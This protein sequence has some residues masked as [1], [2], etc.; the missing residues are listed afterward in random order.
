MNFKIY[1]WETSSS[2]S[3]LVVWKWATGQK[4]LFEAF[5]VGQITFWL[6]NAKCFN[7]AAQQKFYLASR[8]WQSSLL[9]RDIALKGK[10]LARE[11][12]STSLDDKVQAA[13]G[14]LSSFIHCGL[15]K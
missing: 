2:F 12:C 15:R 9:T 10:E 11:S 14:N 13:A 6:N 4:V 7:Q 5:R 8:Y 1:T 3:F